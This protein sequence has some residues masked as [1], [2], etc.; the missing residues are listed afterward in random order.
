MAYE[1]EERLPSAPH[2]LVLDERSRLTVSGVTKVDSFDEELAVIYT[3][4]GNLIV[5]GQGLHLQQLSL[6]QGQVCVDGTV[7]S[8]TYEE[9]AAGSFFA[10]LF[11]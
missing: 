2:K 1:R 4:K 11:G 5:R 3:V 7:Q 10:R 9:P 8:L 6:E